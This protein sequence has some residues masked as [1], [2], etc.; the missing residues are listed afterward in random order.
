MKKVILNLSVPESKRGVHEYIA[1]EMG[2]P[3][4]YGYNLDALYDM[5]TSL[6]EPTAVG[7]FSPTPAFDELDIDLLVYIDKVCD[8]FRDAEFTN[9]ELAVIFGDLLENV[10]PSDD[11]D[12]LDGLGELTDLLDSLMDDDEE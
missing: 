1:E 5:L 2:F 12:A 4:Y 7:V 11:P 8:V 9:P 10:D 3:D 6:T